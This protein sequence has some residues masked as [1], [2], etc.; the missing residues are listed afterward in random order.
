MVQDKLAKYDP[1]E[2]PLIADSLLFVCAEMNDFFEMNPLTYVYFVDAFS[3]YL[4]PERR[5]RLAKIKTDI[6]AGFDDGE[7]AAKPK[8]VQDE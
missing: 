3:P 5:Q 7:S 8:L 4:S 2:H 6:L 1:S